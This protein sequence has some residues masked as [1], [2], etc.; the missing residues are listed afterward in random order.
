L[1]RCARTDGLGDCRAWRLVWADD[2]LCCWPNRSKLDRIEKQVGGFDEG[3]FVATVRTVE[4]ALGLLTKNRNEF[5]R[6]GAAR[7]GLFGSFARGEATE[8]SD[9][10]IIVEFQPGRKSFRN[11]MAIAEYLETLLGR[12][13][14][15]VTPESLSPYI[16]TTVLQEAKY[17]KVG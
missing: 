4:Q 10:D 14:D 11:F 13:V 7:L 12:E 6:L 8:I 5:N 16:K 2:I 15:I 1:P 9:V 17:V 3:G